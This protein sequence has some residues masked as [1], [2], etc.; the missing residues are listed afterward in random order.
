[1][2]FPY[3]KAPFWI[4]VLA[5]LSGAC[6]LVTQV[7]QT[8]RRPDLECTTFAKPHWESY[9]EVLSEFE[10][11]HSV[12]LADG[13][14][15]N[16]LVEFLLVLTQ[17][18]NERLEAAMLTGAKVPDV[19]E[20]GADA[21]AVFARGPIEDIGFV[22]L[23]ERIR[24]DGIDKMM[25]ASRFS[26]WSS[27]GHYFGLPH[28]VHPT[29]LAYRRDLVE[30][31]G[32]DVTKIETWED[33]ARIGR[34]VTRDLNGDG[35]PD[36][37]M[38]DLPSEGG[39]ALTLLCLQRVGRGPFDADGH[40]ALYSEDVVDVIYWL[41]HQTRGRDKISFPAGQG[42]GLS[43]TM[44]DGLVL[45]YFCPDWRT[46]LFEQDVPGLAGKMALMPLPA[47]TP[48]GRRV[49]TWGGTGLFITK[50]CKNP[51][52]AWDL[53]KF[54]YLRKEDLAKRFVKTGI[55]PPVREAWDLPEFSAPNPF[56]SNQPVGKVLADL[57]PGVPESYT[58]PYS[59]LA[60]EKL[61]ETFLNCAVLY[62]EGKGL[63]EAKLR[64]NI[65]AE[66]RRNCD[67]VQRVMDRNVFLKAEPGSAP[68]GASP[69]GAQEAQP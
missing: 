3:G 27:R 1:V 49:S 69:A 18:Q 34:E 31:L 33:F 6:I 65:R 35:T 51:D 28:D 26:L 64:D 39:Y 30:Q 45:F 50:Q 5:L 48:G 60:E 8:G 32:I 20:I 53:A 52:L 4:L 56:F 19:V 12:Q 11:T 7:R 21:M 66:L 68:E 59:K 46:K 29:G 57:A 40:L 58:T 55:I 61:G 24:R 54:L 13:T 2:E 42:Q 37:Y 44:N 43:Q 67:Y 47:W 9:Q 38:M 14:T 23:T 63:D 10:R 25:V 41:I 36:R 62:A 17:A 22:D 16:T 15:T